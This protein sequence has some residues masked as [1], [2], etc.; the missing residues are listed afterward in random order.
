[1]QPGLSSP[2]LF[3]WSIFEIISIPPQL[4]PCL[5]SEALGNHCSITFGEEIS[6]WESLNGKNGALGLAV[7]PAPTVTSRALSAQP[8]ALQAG[9]QRW[10]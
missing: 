7:I 4:P 1:M 9:P 10:K 8:P 3:S 5:S 6:L 2:A